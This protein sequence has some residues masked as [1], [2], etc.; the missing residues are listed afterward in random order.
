MQ[1]SHISRRPKTHLHWKPQPPRDPRVEAR[2]PANLPAERLQLSPQHVFVGLGE[3]A[4]RLASDGTPAQ[5]GRHKDSPL[6]LDHTLVSRQHAELRVVAGNLQVRDLN[7][8]NGTW[9]GETRVEPGK[10][11]QVPQ[12]V[13]LSLASTP[14]NWSNQAPT[15]PPK[16]RLKPEIMTQPARIVG[17]AAVGGPVGLGLT[18]AQLK[19]FASKSEL[20]SKNTL[21]KSIKSARA[22][23]AQD[24][25]IVDLPKGVPTLI[26]PDIHGQRDYLVRALEHKIDGKKVLDRLKDGEMNLLCLG[27]GMHSEG[28]AKDRWKQA[29]R[30]FLADQPSRAMYDEMVES[31]GTMKMVMDLKSQLGDNFCYL[32]GNHDDINPE[33][34]YMKYTRVGES[35][36]VR[37][38]VVKNYGDD[39]L[40]EW[41]SFEKEMPLVAKGTGFVASHAAP[42][43]QLSKQEIQSRSERAFGVLAWTDNTAWSE[44]GSERQI[45]SDNLREVGAKET[46]HWLVGHRKVADANFRGQFDN[47]LIQIN[48]LDTDGFVVGL[49]GADGSYDP[50]RDN[51]RV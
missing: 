15:L 39:L 19:E 21:L 48:P 10:W 25:G 6:R 24:S 13:P 9:L 29:E 28:R 17:A 49:V 41:S 38:W 12:G 37:D 33:H 8:T 7:S 18:L 46:D 35:N 14:L 5:I 45:F 4:I 23:M 27:D 20:E 36:L 47:Q 11:V 1:P 26:I 43:S 30:D 2:R 31:F 40:Q 22:A 42:G 16:T 34:T 51:F 44:N 50:H 32:R 3:Q